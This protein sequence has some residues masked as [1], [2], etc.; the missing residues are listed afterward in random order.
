[1]YFSSGVLGS[2]VPEKDKVPYIITN[3][4]KNIFIIKLSLYFVGLVDYFIIIHPTIF[5]HI[6]IPTVPIHEMP[7]NKMARFT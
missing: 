5:Y 7:K 2:I 3:S 6:L 4:T 1:M